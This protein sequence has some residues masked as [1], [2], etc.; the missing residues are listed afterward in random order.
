ME[1]RTQVE[2]KRSK[3]QQRSLTFVS[4]PARMSAWWSRGG[5][6]LLPCS[7]L[8]FSSVQHNNYKIVTTD[9]P[10]LITFTLSLLLTASRA[11]FFDEAVD[12]NE[13]IV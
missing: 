4:K 11:K 10:I 13:S 9:H 3:R 5:C 1:L 2:Q 8:C 12:L 6:S 7:V